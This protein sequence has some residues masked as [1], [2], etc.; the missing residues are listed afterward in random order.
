MDVYGESVLCEPMVG[1]Y[2]VSILC[3]V[4]AWVFQICQ[5]C[6]S[7]NPGIKLLSFGVTRK[8]R[9]VLVI[10]FYNLKFR[11]IITKIANEITKKRYDI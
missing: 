8:S 11:I 2:G 1:G 10:L 9:D 5:F 7:R 4:G 3:V 6:L